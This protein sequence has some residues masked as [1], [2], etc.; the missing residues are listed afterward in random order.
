[1]KNPELWTEEFFK[2]LYRLINLDGI[3][4]TYSVSQSVRENLAAAGFSCG[5][6]PGFGRKKNF[7]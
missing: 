6:I 2:D 5:L 4:A 7:T 3:L 1:V